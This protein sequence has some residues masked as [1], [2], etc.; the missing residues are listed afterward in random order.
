M[1]AA[2]VGGAALAPLTLRPVCSGERD[3]RGRRRDPP[4]HLHQAAVAG[5]RLQGRSEPEEAAPRE[6]S[7][8]EHLHVPYVHLCLHQLV[9]VNERP[10]MKISEDPKKTTV[11]GRKDVYRLADSQG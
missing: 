2:P 7:P 10:K 8:Q 3:R 6:P 1:A 4:G 11:P 5:L 9:E